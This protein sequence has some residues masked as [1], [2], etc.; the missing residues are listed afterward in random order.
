MRGFPRPRGQLR[1]RGEGV[2]GRRPPYMPHVL[3]IAKKTAAG[4]QPG[5]V[6]TYRSLTPKSCFHTTV[7]FM[8]GSATHTVVRPFMHNTTKINNVVYLA[9]VLLKALKQQNIY[10]WL[11]AQFSQGVVCTTG[12]KRLAP[13][14]DAVNSGEGNTGGGNKQLESGGTGDG[15]DG[16]VVDG[17]TPTVG[18]VEWRDQAAGEVHVPREPQPSSK[19]FAF[20]VGRQ[21]A[22]RF[23]TDQVGA[24]RIDSGCGQPERGSSPAAAT[25]LGCSPTDGRLQPP[26]SSSTMSLAPFVAAG[27][28][29]GTGLGLPGRV[30]PSCT[31]S[32]LPGGSRCPG[33]GTAS[34]G[35]VFKLSCTSSNS[36]S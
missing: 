11:V 21:V 31:G 7:K 2:L 14:S 26:R 12:R 16:Q 30:G 4:K 23:A 10:Q 3:L 33:V 29:G 34:R 17:T 32:R 20:V 9:I 8:D 18:E 5:T 25:V 15:C 36:L 35:R 24:G 13:L 19:A 1:H 28:M 22:A 6:G 27:I